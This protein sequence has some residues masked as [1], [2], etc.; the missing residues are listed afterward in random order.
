MIDA[1]LIPANYPVVQK[2]EDRLLAIKREFAPL[3]GSK[4]AFVRHVNFG[5]RLS[6]DL[7]T[8]LPH[9]PS[10]Y[11]PKGNSREGFDRYVWT[12]IGNGVKSGMLLPD[13][14]EEI[15]NFLVTPSGQEFLAAGLQYAASVVTKERTSA[16]E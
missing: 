11:F 10:F 1:F 9:S 5:A 16:P 6:L 8:P 4:R 15:K 3:M 12:D 7:V 2:R 13:P 14:D